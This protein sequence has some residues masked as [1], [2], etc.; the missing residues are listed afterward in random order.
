MAAVKVRLP[1]GSYIVYLA[2]FLLGAFLL[3]SSACTVNDIL[4]RKMDAGVRMY[5]FCCSFFCILILLALENAQET[6][7]LRVAALQLRQQRS[8]YLFNIFSGYSSSI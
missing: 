8:I 4:D 1:L 2:K 6:A 5:H 7:H 3:R